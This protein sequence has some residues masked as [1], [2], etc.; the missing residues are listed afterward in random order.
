MDFEG[1]NRSITVR[2]VNGCQAPNPRPE[3]AETDELVWGE[4]RLR[5]LLN[6]LDD[7][8][9]VATPDGVVVEW[10]RAAISM[11]SYLPEQII[12]R[13][14]AIVAGDDAEVN[15]SAILEL[16]CEG[17]QLNVRAKWRTGM[18]R[19]VQVF[20]KFVPVR[21]NDGRTFNVLAIVRKLE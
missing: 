20:A 13:P 10:S 15:L 16:V 18:G 21:D 14:L 12:G 1:L 2:G 3:I 8:I 11:F 17:K 6:D 9:I 19:I 5:T 7:A 4:A